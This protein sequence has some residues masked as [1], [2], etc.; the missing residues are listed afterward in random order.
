MSR[1][2]QWLVDDDDLTLTVPLQS[3]L[4]APEFREECTDIVVHPSFAIAAEPVTDQMPALGVH[5]YAS[6]QSAFDRTPEFPS[7]PQF[8]A[9]SPVHSAP[10]RPIPF[11]PA[12]SRQSWLP[13]PRA[14]LDSDTGI[15]TW[16]KTIPALR[17]MIG[18]PGVR[19][20]APAPEPPPRPT[21]NTATTRGSWSPFIL[22]AASIGAVAMVVLMLISFASRA[23]EASRLAHTRVVS[24]RSPDGAQV[25]NGRVFV[26]GSAHCES[27]PCELELADGEHWI[28][29]RA[30]G[31]RTPPSRS[32]TSGA[33]EAT[34]VAF[35]LSP[36]E[37][38]P[39]P[40]AV[41][42]PTLAAV[43]QP[44]PRAALVLPVA[45]APVAAAPAPAAPAVVRSAWT[46]MGRLNVNSIPA[47]NVV[48]DGR[49]IGHT[50]IMGFKVKPGAHTVVLIGP[51]G[52]RAVR[53]ATV[54]AGRTATVAARL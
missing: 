51:G 28:T 12:P 53:T 18:L 9:S 43:A 50:P 30:P 17:R 46:A 52:S 22:I 5:P 35:D 23:A 33:Q 39:T 21:P 32:I 45:P 20:L 15:S 31:Y 8:H 42:A 13:A 34:V 49:P 2:A 14:R 27:T 44:E 41:A 48:V 16:K 6:V 7:A 29:V 36:S 26:D 4:R 3:V 11:T 38:L 24:A 40:A 37:A 19:A 10:S 25:T 47:S 54:G 1:H